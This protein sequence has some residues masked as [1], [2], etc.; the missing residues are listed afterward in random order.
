MRILI[1]G[2]TGF[3]SSHLAEELLVRN[4]NICPNNGET[5]VNYINL[6]FY[7]LK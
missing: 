1:A 2:G 6:N 5:L 7:I 3:I 4:N